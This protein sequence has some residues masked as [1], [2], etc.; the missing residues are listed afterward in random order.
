M[1]GF[2]MVALLLQADIPLPDGGVPATGE[3]YGFLLLRMVFYLAL[4]CLAI[5]AVLRFVMPRF[6]RWRMPGGGAMT[7]IDRISIGAGRTVCVIRAVGRYY[8]VGVS[9]GGVRM[10]KELDEK[11]V[12]AH[13]PAVRARAG[14][15]ESDESKA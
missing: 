8:L 14:I 5:Y 4:I 2:P 10:M 7:V 15:K 13:Y 11:D 1:I 3:S 9:D 12:F 6:F